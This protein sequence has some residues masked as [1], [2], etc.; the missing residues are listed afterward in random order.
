VEKKELSYTVGGGLIS[1]ASIK[2][3]VKVPATTLLDIYL[4][5][6]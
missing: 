3:G 2:I 1:A 6:M 4:K 5:E